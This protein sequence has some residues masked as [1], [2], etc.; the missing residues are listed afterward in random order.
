M[1]DVMHLKTYTGRR[2][3][4]IE[5]AKT[6]CGFM[7]PAFIFLI[8]IV[9]FPLAASANSM[10][11]KAMDL[12]AAGRYS[13]AKAAAHSSGSQAAIAAVTWYELARSSNLPSFSAYEQF[14]SRY[15]GW[16][17]EEKLKTRAEIA[18]LGNHPSDGA[19]ASWFAKH[20]AQ[21]AYGR[22]LSTVYKRQ[23][24]TDALIV[25]T[26]IHADFTIA[27]ENEFYQRYK[28]KLTRDHHHKRA[29]RLIWE[30]RLSTAQAMFPRLDASYR[31]LFEARIKLAQ[32]A[33]SVDGYVDRV[34]ASLKNDPG[35]IY[36]RMRWRAGKKNYKGVEELLLLA[37]ASVPYP[38]KWWP[39]RQRAIREALDRKDYG[40]AYRLA[41]AHSQKE[42]FERSEAL[43]LKG[44]IALVFRNSASEAYSDFTQMYEI[45]SYPISRSRAAYWAGRAAKASG[46]SDASAWFKKAGEHP[47]TF[48]G[49]LALLELSPS[50]VLSIPWPATPKPSDAQAALNKTDLGRVVLTLGQADALDAAWPFLLHLIET[51]GAES[52]ARALVLTGQHFNRMDVSLRA[53]KEAQRFGWTFTEAAF[54]VPGA[55]RIKHAVETAYALAISR[56]ESLFNTRALSPAGARGLMQIMPATG[57]LVA[58]KHKLPHNNDKLYDP[59]HNIT[60]GTLYLQE[61]LGR[62]NGHH[63]L[64]TAGYNAGP[65]RPVQWQGRNGRL[66]P[67]LYQTINWIEMIP[68]NETRNYVQRVLENQQVYRY[69]LTQGKQPLTLKNVLTGR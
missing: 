25:D 47:T 8:I 9:L 42:R 29:D 40:T 30:G 46:K 55:Y 51:A 4:C 45:V 67:D 13:E 64:A 22:Y 54:P 66:G 61:L 17:S 5:G 12:A 41:A 69:L 18:L 65:G 6:L 3:K 31:A 14:L 16:P 10:I 23:P 53:A 27:K 33:R 36:E 60:L 62:F 48:Y 63:V 68:F 43:W 34:P 32:K 56:Q 57:R 59:D 58:S 39:Y 37:P 44:W 19:L 28:A 11:R 38:E 49:Q 7:R 26:W 24:V 21:T 52:H 50:A 20:P 1:K 15:P 2:G 35:L